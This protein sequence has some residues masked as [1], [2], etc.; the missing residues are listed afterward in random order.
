MFRFLD[1]LVNDKQ[2]DRII[3][4]NIRKKS[5]SHIRIKLA[6]FLNEMLYVFTLFCLGGIFA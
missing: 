5:Q 1:D 6:L 2:R 4:G 3:N